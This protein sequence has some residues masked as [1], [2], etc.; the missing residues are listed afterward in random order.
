M[1]RVMIFTLEEAKTGEL[2]AVVRFLRSLQDVQDV[3]LLN[4]GAPTSKNELVLLPE[5]VDEE[6]LKVGPSSSAEKLRV[7]YVETPQTGIRKM[8][9]D[10]R[11][12]VEG[13]VTVTDAFSFQNTQEAAE[14]RRQAEISMYRRDF[15][16]SA[17]LA[18]P[19]FVFSMVLMYI[20]V[21]KDFVKSHAVWNISVEELVTWILATPVQFVSG[22]RFYRESYYSLRSGHYGMGFLICVGTSAAYFYSVFAVLSN[23]VRDAES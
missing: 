12:M 18:L 22:A 10:V 16:F 5:E 4:S 9:R 13:G 7:T 21:T 23:A 1:V 6:N 15:L 14:A 11:A 2:Q 8:L 19:I 17:F 20:P 3:T